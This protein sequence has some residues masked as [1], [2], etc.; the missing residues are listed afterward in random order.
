MREQFI[1]YEQALKLKELGFDELCFKVYDEMG[2]LQDEEEMDNLGLIKVNA[3]LW[4]QGFDWFRISFLNSFIY[5][6]GRYTKE[7]TFW[8]FVVEG[9]KT[10]SGYNSYE[11]ARLEF[12]N[13]LIELI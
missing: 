11:Q 4:Q 2:C 5:P 13:K 6:H 12:L 7:G 10:Y 9:D 8:G 3:P 1:P